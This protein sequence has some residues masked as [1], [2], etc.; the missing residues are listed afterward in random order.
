MKVNLTD[1]SLNFGMV[2]A[3]SDYD[4]YEEKVSEVN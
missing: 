2:A 4:K 1:N 3:M